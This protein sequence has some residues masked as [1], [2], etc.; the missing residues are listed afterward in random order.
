VLVKK[1][2]WRGE[3]L[4]P[5]YSYIEVDQQSDVEKRDIALAEHLNELELPGMRMS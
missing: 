2:A 1:K 5:P 3:C 4:S